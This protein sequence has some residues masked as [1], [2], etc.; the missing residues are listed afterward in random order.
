MKRT[1]VVG[2]LR[3]HPSSCGDWTQHGKES[4]SH[5][6][7]ETI[8]ANPGRLLNETG[9]SNNDGVYE[10]LA[11]QSMMYQFEAVCIRYVLVFFLFH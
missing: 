5:L 2:R 9:L 8:S 6:V 7:L 11:Y 10:T 3:C 1:S 4:D